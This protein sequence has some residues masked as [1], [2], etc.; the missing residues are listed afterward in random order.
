M[1]LLLWVLAASIIA[2]FEEF[3]MSVLTQHPKPFLEKPNSNKFIQTQKS[4][5]ALHYSN[6]KK[7]IKKN[8]VQRKEISNLVPH[9]LF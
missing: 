8:V 5:R 9:F 3:C 7:E 1:V 6:N 4:N 2:R